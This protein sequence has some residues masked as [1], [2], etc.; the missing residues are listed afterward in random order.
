MNEN[1]STIR[2]VI[3]TKDS[4]IL[5]YR[6]NIRGYDTYTVHPMVSNAAINVLK[7]LEKADTTCFIYSDCIEYNVKG[8]PTQPSIVNRITNTLTP[9]KALCNDFP[10]KI[11]NRSM[12]SHLIYKNI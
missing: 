12:L 5:S 8:A 3:I 10:W 6:N 1:I 2:R 9:I 7:M 11:R 4:I